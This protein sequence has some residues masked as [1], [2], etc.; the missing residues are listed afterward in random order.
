MN[1]IEGARTNLVRE[2]RCKEEEVGGETMET[3]RRERWLRKATVGE[4]A[5]AVASWVGAASRVGTA[6][7]PGPCDIGIGGGG[8]G[9]GDG[10]TGEGGGSAGGVGWSEIAPAA[11]M[12]A[13][14]APAPAASA[15]AALAASVGASGSDSMFR[16]VDF[17]LLERFSQEHR[18]FGITR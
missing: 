18:Q 2:G 15:R 13:G 10:T 3:S 7:G 8:A 6:A 14:P 4:E 9:G 12:G 17:F 1:Q 16:G 5:A 11:S